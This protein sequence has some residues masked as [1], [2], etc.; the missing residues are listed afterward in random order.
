[1]GISP[2]ICINSR[3]IEESCE[4]TSVC[5]DDVQGQRYPIHRGE[6]EDQKG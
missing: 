3:A 6:Q 4:D 1:M 5:T 2:V